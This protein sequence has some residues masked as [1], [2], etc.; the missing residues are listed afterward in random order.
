MTA[1][2]RQRQAAPT[3]Y[4]VSR[5][6]DRRRIRELLEPERAYSAYALAQLDP[7][8]F[9]LNEWY[10]SSGPSGEALLVHSFSGLGRALFA[11]GDAQA[12]DA[13]LSLHPGP[14]FAF[15]SMKAE[16]KP[17]LEKYFVLTRPQSMLRMSVTS[18]SFSPAA[19]EAFR[20][21]PPDVP[22]VN[23]LYSAEGGPTAYKT[24]HMEEGVYYGV[25]VDG[26]LVAI[27]GTHVVS[28]VE[29]IAVVGNVFTHPRY[30]GRG[31]ATI[32][33]SAVTAELLRACDPVVLT[34]EERNLPAVALYT[35]LGYRTE[36]HLH[37]TPLIRKEPLGI[38]SA[39]RRG[40]AGWRGRH[41]GKEVVIK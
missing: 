13:V 25:R 27:A 11:T 6:E 17:V 18:R 5:L 20:L 22:A 36:C 29:R 15:G 30:R 4:E 21:E 7:R 35:K 3:A 33:T 19:G 37:E 24:A 28:P 8:L 14:R 10:L 41:E 38:V 9:P 2:S 1:V 32:A 26:G 34:V 31:L 40:I 16:H 39:V 12:L 23:R